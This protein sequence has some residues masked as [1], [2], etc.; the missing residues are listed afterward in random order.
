MHIPKENELGETVAR[1]GLKQ[2]SR[3]LSGATGATT[4]GPKSK[5]S[6]Q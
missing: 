5:G 3:T 6:I 1:E 2:P 4:L